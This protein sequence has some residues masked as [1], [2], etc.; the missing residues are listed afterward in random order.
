MA[1]VGQVVLDGVRAKEGNIGRI[2]REVETEP[3]IGTQKTGDV[4]VFRP[5]SVCEGDGRS[6]G[7]IS[8]YT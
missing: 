5:T 2:S 6:S 8:T 3:M 1:G 4:E 7:D